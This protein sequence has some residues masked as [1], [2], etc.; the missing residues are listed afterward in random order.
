VK[1]TSTLAAA[2]KVLDGLGI[3]ADLQHYNPVLAGTFPIDINIESSDLDLLCQVYDLDK[4]ATEIRSLY[5]T[6]EKFSLH[7]TSKN[8]L[9]VVI[10]RFH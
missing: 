6:Q 9:P 3:F 7:R 8:D 4:F 5:E 2:N 10:A 1:T